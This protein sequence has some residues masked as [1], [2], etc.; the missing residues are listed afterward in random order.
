MTNLNSAPRITLSH[1]EIGKTYQVVK[2]AGRDETIKHINDL[3]LIMDSTVT[4]V[5][6]AAGNMI[7]NIK[8]ARIGIGK[9]LADKVTV[10]EVG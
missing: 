7:L 8:E 5:N 9:D 1:G 2:I 4:L 3:G 10:V 6:S